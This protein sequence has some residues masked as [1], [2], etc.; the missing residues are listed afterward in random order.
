MEVGCPGRWGL[1]LLTPK[2]R[3]CRT[4]NPAMGSW[5]SDLIWGTQPCVKKKRRKPCLLGQLHVTEDLGKRANLSVDVE[6]LC[7]TRLLTWSLDKVIRDYSPGNCYLLSCCFEYRARITFRA[8]NC[9]VDNNYCWVKG[10]C[11]HS[12]T[13]AL[14]LGHTM[15]E[16]Y[17]PLPLGR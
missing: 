5:L 7:I 6:L 17:W 16:S 2:P 8:Q 15:L 10:N 12:K 3:A 1:E 13:A 14:R 9:T 11:H 4:C